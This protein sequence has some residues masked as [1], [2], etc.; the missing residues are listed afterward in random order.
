MQNSYISGDSGTVKFA[1]SGI[2]L[3]EGE[4]IKK[5]VLTSSYTQSGTADSSARFT[6]N[7]SSYSSSKRFE[8]TDIVNG[9][10]F[11]VT[12]YLQA[13][14]TA[15]ASGSAAS[16]NSYSLTRTISNMVLTVTIGTGNAFDGKVS[17]LNEGDKIII[18]EASGTGT[19][20]L[21]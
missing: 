17:S 14:G 13:S 20:T 8:P 5:V 4:S 11:T 16:P 3:G 18:T 10:N 21:V 2:T 7:G 6:M 1:I 9:T 15:G 19:Y 12:F